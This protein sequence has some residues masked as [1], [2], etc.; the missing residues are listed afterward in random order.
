[1]L[2]SILAWLALLSPVHIPSLSIRYTNTLQTTFRVSFL[3]LHS[4]WVMKDIVDMLET[5]PIMNL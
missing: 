2:L 4:I 3:T 5:S 1:M